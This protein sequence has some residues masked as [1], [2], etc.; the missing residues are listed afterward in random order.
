[1]CVGGVSIEGIVG[2]HRIHRLNSLGPGGDPVQKRDLM[3]CNHRFRGDL[4]E[5]S[6][7]GTRAHHENQEERSYQRHAVEPEP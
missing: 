1:M 2:R 6:G 4:I 3:L 5:V 7:R